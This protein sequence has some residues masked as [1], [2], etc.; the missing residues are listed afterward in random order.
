LPAAIVKIVAAWLRLEQCTLHMPDAIKAEE[1]YTE[2]EHVRHK[3][4]NF[5]SPNK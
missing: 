2:I 5:T 4:S 3:Y 1:K